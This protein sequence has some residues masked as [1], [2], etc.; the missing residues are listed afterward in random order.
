LKI[1][2]V[3]ETFSPFKGGSSRRYREVFE[4]IARAGNEVHLYTARL[5]PS[6]P[7]VEEVGGIVVHRSKRAYPNFIT[8]DGFRSVTDVIAFALWSL[9]EMRNEEP[10]DLIEA[11]HCPVFPTLASWVRSRMSST[12][13]SVTFHEVWYDEWYRY[14]PRRIYAPMGMNLE[15]STTLIPDLAI[16]VSQ[17]TATRL[18]KY[19]QVPQRKIRVISNGVDLG[20]YDHGE[21]QRDQSKVLFL[22]RLNPH[23][24]IEWLLG[25]VETLLKDYPEMRLDVIGEGPMNEVYR[26]YVSSNGLKASVRFMGGLDDEEVAR[27]LR[28][29]YLYVLPSIREGQSITLLEAMAAGTPQIVVKAVGNAAG[30][31]LAESESG[32]V[33]QP[34]SEGIAFAIRRLFEDRSLWQ[35]LNERSLRFASDFSWDR[36]AQEHMEAYEALVSD[37][38]RGEGVVPIPA[39][40]R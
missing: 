26:S 17:T 8:G 7:P 3:T 25:A 29:S 39:T 1:A 6:W 4:R 5:N 36:I 16:A 34:S 24:K 28:S 9:R 37:W 21:V 22:G 14:V 31:L 20:L 32:L 18:M 33:A 15:R 23:K 38:H 30:D 35:D 2:V 19:F 40:H 11:N 27:E 10:F 13:L 12:P